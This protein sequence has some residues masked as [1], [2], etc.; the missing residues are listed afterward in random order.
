MPD[1]QSEPGQSPP[2]AEIVAGKTVAGRAL[3][4]AE[5]VRILSEQ[6]AEARGR[7]ASVDIGLATVERDSEIGGGL[8]A[9]AL[10]YRLFV[11]L[12]PF[13]VFLV[14]GLGLYADVTDQ[15]TADVA[16]DLGLTRIVAR[17]IAGAAN[18]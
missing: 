15:T 5:R 18:D 14:V 6:I 8:L 2:E 12:L 7:H 17:E 11:F 4:A 9:G 10:A 13:A 16:D 3:A 1:Q